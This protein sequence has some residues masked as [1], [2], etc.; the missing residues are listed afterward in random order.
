MPGCLLFI[1]L[2]R[3][4]AS[5]LSC[6]GAWHWWSLATHKSSTWQTLHCLGWI[7]SGESC[8]T[9]I[10]THCSELTCVKKLRGGRQSAW[11]V[12]GLALSLALLERLVGTCN[13]LR[14]MT[15]PPVQLPVTWVFSVARACTVKLY[16]AWISALS[17]FCFYI[18]SSAWLHGQ[19]WICFL[20]HWSMVMCAS[21][22]QI[23]E[24]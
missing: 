17:G 24:L 9:G 23:Q 20:L 3:M 22:M 8:Y 12:G 6:K 7:S 16:L 19:L 14:G 4:C 13:F 1:S 5:C 10:K 21:W 15:S 2:L 18:P 11:R